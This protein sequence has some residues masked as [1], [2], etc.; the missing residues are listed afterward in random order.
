MS[1]QK[2]TT[3]YHS[4]G[5]DRQHWFYRNGEL[6]PK[7]QSPT[8]PQKELIEKCMAASNMEQRGEGD[9]N[10]E[11]ITTSLRSERESGKDA[12]KAQ[13]MG[14]GQLRW[15][16]EGDEGMLAATDNNNLEQL[17]NKPRTL[18]PEKSLTE[19]KAKGDSNIDLL[20]GNKRKDSEYMQVDSDTQETVEAQ[21][22][23]GTGRNKQGGQ[24]AIQ[25]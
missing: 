19:E 2:E 9:R 14:R 21:K 25:E 23:K 1:P 17:V 12:G 10:Q 3:Y 16:Q 18:Q 22:P 7:F 6:I 11:P 24:N 4:K 20:E 5:N 8:L 13:E 15:E